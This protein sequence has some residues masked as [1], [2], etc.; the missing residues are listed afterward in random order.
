MQRMDLKRTQNI[1][2]QFAW[3]GR[4]NNER[5]GNRHA[6]GL[7][8]DDA[9][10]ALGN[11]RGGND[12]INLVRPVLLLLLLLWTTTPRVLA[13]IGSG[14]AEIVLQGNHLAQQCGRF[15]GPDRGL[16]DPCAYVCQQ[17]VKQTKE[18]PPS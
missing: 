18:T 7:A 12:N 2:G 6:L 8:L 15:S 17:T 5:K 4:F 9:Q 11:R 10:Y 14:V 16:D 13:G 3:L 1:L